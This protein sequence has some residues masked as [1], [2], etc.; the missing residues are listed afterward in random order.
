MR[1]DKISIVIPCYNSENTIKTVVDDVRDSLRELSC[2]YE[3]ILVNDGSKDNTFEMISDLVSQDKRVIGIDLARNF[4]QHNAIMA[5]LNQC[6][7]EV[8]VCMDDDGQTPATGIASLLTGIK[9]GYDVVYARYN[10][11]QH[12]LFRNLG[13]YINDIMARVM[14]GKPKELYLSSFFCMKKYVRDEIVKYNNPYPYMM[15]LVLRCTRS[16]TNVDIIHK[17]RLTGESGYTFAKLF[18]LW[19]NGF[20]AFSVKPLRIATLIGSLFAMAGF[21]YGIFI[22]LKKLIYDTAPIG[23]SSLTAM[24]MFIGGVMMLMQG[25]VGEYIG[26]IYLSINK[27]PQYV[28]KEILAARHS[29]GNELETIVGDTISLRPMSREDTEYIVEWRNS[30]SVQHNFRYREVFTSETHEK[31]IDDYIETGRA[32]QYIIETRTNREPIGSVFFRDI[33]NNSEEAEFG[34]FIGETGFRGKGYGGEA[35]RLFTDFGFN[36]L[37]LKRIK[38]R[39][40]ED[41]AAAVKSYRK[42]GFVCVDDEVENIKDESG[43]VRKMIHM[44]KSVEDEVI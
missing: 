16:I 37:G 19:V 11:K 26:R 30:R 5:G 27:S 9:S 25:M 32:V 36:K 12:S 7:G 24:L 14:I 8:I 29:N 6:C 43:A 28:I 39:V 31:W 4:G 38:L 20:T 1:Q 22:I 40:F 3:I 13:S 2:D 21:L 15:G 41:N 42:A 23:W 35:V 33:D 17:G 10:N 44:Q 34:I 18:G